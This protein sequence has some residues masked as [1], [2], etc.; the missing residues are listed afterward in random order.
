MTVRPLAAVAIASI[1]VCGK[2]SY[3]GTLELPAAMTLGN[4]SQRVDF[5]P[6]LPIT[7]RG[8]LSL[9]WTDSAGR[10]I[11]EDSRPVDPGAGDR[12]PFALD[13][14]RAVPALNYLVA[15]LTVDCSGAACQPEK[16]RDTAE[17]TFVTLAP[18]ANW[19]DYQIIMWQPQS[20]AAFA[21]LRR[22]G[23]T[24][25]KLF[26][27]EQAL[28]V[29]GGEAASLFASGL[30]WY[31]ENIATDFYAPY[32]RFFPDRAVNWRYLALQA[33]HREEPTSL[34][35]F[36]RRPSL[37]DPAWRK[38]VGLRL[39]NVA[40]A[41]KALRPLYYSLGDETGIADLAAYWDFDYSPVSLEVF[42]HWLES[43]YGSLEALNRQWDTSFQE[44]RD[45]MPLTA[46]QTVGR[47]GEN[48]SAW[49]D[50]R[51]WMDI[52]FA[53]ALREGRDALH[54][55]DPA[56]LAAIEGGQVPGWGGYDYALLATAVDA[57]ELYDFGNNI[58]MARSFRPEA[59]VLT[60]SGGSDQVERLRIWRQALRGASGLILWDEK[61][62][63]AGADGDLGPRGKAMAGQFAELRGGIGALLMNSPTEPAAVAIHYSPASFRTAWMIDQKRQ[64]GAGLEA[65]TNADHQ[66][67][68]FTV[69][70]ESLCDL[71]SDLGIAYGFV[72][73]PALEA[74]NWPAGVPR[75]LI[76]PRSLSLSVAEAAGIRRF[77]DQGGTVLALDQPGTFDEHGRKRPEPLLPGLA[78][79]AA[80]PLLGYHRH[81]RGPRADQ[82]RRQISPK[83]RAAGGGPAV[84]LV[85]E[86][87]GGAVTGVAI[88]RRRNGSVTILGLLNT[89][90]QAVAAAQSRTILVRLAETSAVTDLRNGQ[91]FGNTE[92]VRV[93]LPACEPV[94]MSLSPV[95]LPDVTIEAPPSLRL[96]ETG[97]VA[98]GRTGNSPD[99]VQIFHIE[100]R[101]PDGVLMDHYGANLRTTSGAAE[102]LLPLALNDPPGRWS[103]TVRDAVSGRQ[104]TSVVM[105][106]R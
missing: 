86:Q 59:P 35:P 69:L 60:S 2:V 39:R 47:P 61:G 15:S 16:S 105:V 53:D 100:V 76:L 98:V 29:K 102:H 49:A 24:A 13:L 85:D 51:Q 93:T 57:F 22:Q 89:D 3:A 99:A 56:A 101:N 83:L 20:P 4:G 64:R 7:G 74:G 66:P 28:D 38:D 12:I 27:K 8:V 40:M 32:H 14:R 23:V 46:A 75:V 96:G 21:T 94:I 80:G 50:F 90:A 30:G 87:A 65:A 81:P 72:S 26:A 37:A 9:R 44:W 11:V 25:G 1:I 18:P 58:E 97:T 34:A 63:F 54:A 5:L 52:S 77:I 36:M 79:K 42:R 103:I 91:D 106:E 41:Q 68:D 33:Q 104:E 48:F 31:D 82:V 19:W 70:R 78:I 45:V 73:S 43:H 67:D 17:A 10:L 71:L 55:G 6:S 84:R 92:M 62:D 95:P 88:T